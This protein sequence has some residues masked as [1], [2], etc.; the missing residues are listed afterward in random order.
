MLELTKPR[1]NAWDMKD[2]SVVMWI[3][4]WVAV[5]SI[6]DM[7]NLGHHIIGVTL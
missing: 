5:F 2:K 1:R 3:I 4:F 7:A 6:R